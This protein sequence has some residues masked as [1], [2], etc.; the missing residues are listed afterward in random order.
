M[1]S[2]KEQELIE[3]KFSIIKNNRLNEDS[4][5]KLD[6]LLELQTEISN[7]N[8]PILI[9]QLER[10]KKILIKVITQEEINLL[11]RIHQELTQIQNQLERSEVQSTE[12]KSLEVLTEKE[13][14]EIQSK[15][16]LI[17]WVEDGWKLREDSQKTFRELN[18]WRK[19]QCNYLLEIWPQVIGNPSRWNEG[20]WK[21]FDNYFE[22]LK[23]QAVNRI[24]LLEREAQIQIIPS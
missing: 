7:N 11:L 19:E 15:F 4:R 23:Q 24:L 8:L 21:K 6:N 9:K 10:T 20:K 5:E 18:N 17:W 16:A 13:K 22:Q 3:I 1:I 12:E 2:K 14:L